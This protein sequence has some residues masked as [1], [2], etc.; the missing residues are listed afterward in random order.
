MCGIAGFL[1]GRLAD[2][3]PELERRA[4]AMGDALAHR[5]PDGAGIWVDA[6]SG[7]AFAHRRLA[8]IDLTPTGAQPMVSADGR[9]V[10]CYN[11]EVYNAAEL[12][13]E[14]DLAGHPWRGHS[15]TEVILELVARRG[16]EATIREL[17]GMFAIALWD[18]KLR[19]LHLARDRVGIKPLFYKTSDVGCAFGSELKALLALPE[20]RPDIDPA[21]VASFIRYAYVPAPHTIFKGVR[22][23][24]PGEMA[25]IRF[26]GSG[27]ARVEKSRYWNVADVARDGI[28]A[29]F[30]MSDA[31][32]VDAL[33]ALLKDAVARQ[34]MGDVP[35]GAFLSGGID[36]ST[37]VAL[38]VAAGQGPVRTFS[39]GFDEPGFDESPY[40]AAVARHLGTDHTELTARPA[41]ALALVPTLADHFDEPFADSS[42]IP[43]LLVSKLTRAHV[44]VALSGDGGDELFAGYNRYRLAEQLVGK[45]AAVPAPLRR[46]ASALL[47]ALPAALVNDIGN[48]LPS[49]IRV[50]QVGDK[51]HKL[52]SV[53]PLDG[54]G[55]YRRLVSQNVDPDVL[56]PTAPE[57][58]GLDWR[59]LGANSLPTLLDKMQLADTTTYLP[60]DILQKVDRASMAVSLEARPPLLDHRVVEFAWRLPRHFKVRNGET[61]WIL[62]RVLDQFVPRALI[63]R[64]K[65][66]FGIPL[67][68]WLRGPLRDWSEDL[69]DPRTLGGGFLDAQAVRTRWRE[70][71][72]PRNHAYG[73]WNILMFEAWRRRWATGA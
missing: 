42:Q 59:G 31:Q 6:A 39:I 24:L 45:L 72:G 10:I 69:L 23:L 64:P 37:V 49:A 21:S 14:P 1:D 13:H 52:A 61:K 56:A 66:G 25:S 36:S 2:R 19:T 3:G 26:D 41:D 32:A 17:N 8:I 15:D 55:I 70:H 20:P 60:D 53:L 48:A 65:M 4:K 54:E 11:G 46:G 57:H 44:T 71:L 18:R 16:F 9:Y 38:M 27:T 63:D 58:A 33:T 67:G 29:Q 40:A 68:E 62:R 7:L 47:Q 51:A 43:T 30:E 50:P 34:M 12:R 73:L 35:L 22:K 5:G 28:G